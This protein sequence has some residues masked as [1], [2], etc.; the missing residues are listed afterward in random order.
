M[1]KPTAQVSGSWPRQA[2]FAVATAALPQF[3]ISLSDFEQI[4]IALMSA[5][6]DI[7]LYVHQPALEELREHAVRIDDAHFTVI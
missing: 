3:G 7:R 1:W 6:R 4:A 2:A 5:R